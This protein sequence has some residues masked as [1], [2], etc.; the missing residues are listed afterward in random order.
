MANQA[1]LEQLIINLKADPEYN[2]NTKEKR[3]TVEKLISLNRAAL[4]NFGNPASVK[5]VTTVS[6]FHKTIWRIPAAKRFLLDSVWQLINEEGPDG[7]LHPVIVLKDGTTREEISSVIRLLS[8]HRDFK[9]NELEWTQ[10]KYENLKRQSERDIALK[11]AG[12][13]EARKALEEKMADKAYM[14]ALAKTIPKE[15]QDLRKYWEIR[16][17]RTD[18]EIH[19]EW[20]KRKC[21]PYSR[22]QQPYVP[23]WQMANGR[24]NAS[25]SSDDSSMDQDDSN[26]DEKR[27]TSSE[28]EPEI[29]CKECGRALGSKLIQDDKTY[30][31]EYIKEIHGV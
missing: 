21:D 31:N 26:E 10:D 25:G 8:N 13:E 16:R 4:T 20:K 11:K 14:E 23:P 9:P 22:R 3:E 7:D 12:R 19:E 6:S 30:N 17:P 27:D 5:Q 24:H 29:K 18:K 1:H 15:A 2:T 28:E